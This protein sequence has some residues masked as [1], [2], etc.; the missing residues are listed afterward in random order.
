LKRIIFI[1][2]IFALFLFVSCNNEEEDPIYYELQIISLHGSTTG[3][4][5]YLKDS[6][7][8]VEAH[9]FDGYEFLSWTIND[10]IVSNSSTYSFIITENTTLQ[11]VYGLLD[12]NT[13]YTYTLHCDTDIEEYTNIE[14]YVIN[15][16]TAKEI[17]AK[18]FVGWYL[19]DTFEY[20]LEFPY[21]LNSNVDFYAYYIDIPELYAVLKTYFNINIP[22][23]IEDT[24]STCYLYEEYEDYLG[25]GI[26]IGIFESLQP[27]LHSAEGFKNSYT[28]F[29][30]NNGYTLMSFA[31]AEGSYTLLIDPTSTIGI[32][33][34]VSTSIIGNIN[35]WVTFAPEAQLDGW[36]TTEINK[37][38]INLPVILGAT[39]YSIHKNVKNMY[40]IEVFGSPITAVEYRILLSELNYTRMFYSFVGGDYSFYSSDEI[41]IVEPIQFSDTEIDIYFFKVSQVETELYESIKPVYSELYPLD[42]LQSIVSEEVLNL[43]IKPE[44]DNLEY[45]YLD[46]SRFYQ[47]PNLAGLAITN[48]SSSNLEDYL[49]SLT[50]AGWY[51]LDDLYYLNDLYDG[52]YIV[53]DNYLDG[54]IYLGIGIYYYHFSDFDLFLAFIFDMLIND[55]ETFSNDINAISLTFP[56]FDSI[57]LADIYVYP[58]FTSARYEIYIPNI[59]ETEVI[60]Y[61]NTIF[62]NYTFV[63]GFGTNIPSNPVNYDWLVGDYILLSDGSTYFHIIIGYYTQGQGS[64]MY[65][66]FRV[67]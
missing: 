25:L 35:M 67:W 37:Q 5:L 8:V 29:L 9:P 3:E 42:D 50:D 12:T 45:Y 58:D 40:Y 13:Y 47:I 55:C 27:S 41:W 62:S 4:G 6:Q 23:A 38:G 10:L 36:P 65:L 48:F 18:E 43:L 7:V 28:E 39:A 30:I 33:L 59:L 63:N 1:L 54:T 34:I 60:A 15:S 2:L 57:N 49:S 21:I 16:L 22:R 32:E 51:T 52:I 20:E 24:Y 61:G 64:G 53:L 56:T 44:Y 19:D 17:Y 66:S 46:R 31:Y 11:A 26:V 14:G